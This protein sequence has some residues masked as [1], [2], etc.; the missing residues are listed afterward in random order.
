MELKV[1]GT[2]EPSKLYEGDCPETWQYWYQDMANAKKHWDYI[3][4][5]G[6]KY[7]KPLRNDADIILNGISGLDYF[8][9]ILEYIYTITNNFQ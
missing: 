6:E 8:T 7:I 1:I 9:I 5:A 4:D 3:I 2:L